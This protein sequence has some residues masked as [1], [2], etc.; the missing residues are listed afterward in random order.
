M[1]RSANDNI[2]RGRSVD[3]LWIVILQLSIVIL[4][5]ETMGGQAGYFD[6]QVEL[7][8]LP[9]FL[10]RSRPDADAASR[11]WTLL[12]HSPQGMA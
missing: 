11:A 7:D 12:W 9:A 4:K 8:R 10:V 5:A 3:L 2:L 6:N 1:D